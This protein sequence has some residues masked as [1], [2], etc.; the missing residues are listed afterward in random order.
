MSLRESIP[1]RKD[2]KEGLINM[3]NANSS[4]QNGTLNVKVSSIQLQLLA[5]IYNLFPFIH[6]FL[7]IFILQENEKSVEVYQALGTDSY[8]KM[9]SMHLINSF[10][11]SIFFRKYISRYFYFRIQ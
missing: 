8:Y 7:I 5:F 3:Q 10:K 6:K 4:L 9:V 11:K 1:K 2:W